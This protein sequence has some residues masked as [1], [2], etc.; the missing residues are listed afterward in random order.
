[1]ING[2]L[3]INKE[4]D[5]TSYDVIRQLKKILPKGQK[6]GHAGTLDPFAT[7]L[8][9]I[10]LGRSTKKMDDILKMNREYI[11]KA[12]FGYATDTQDVTGER[13]LQN[14]KLKEIQQEDIQREIEDEFSGIIKQIPPIYSAKK[15]KGKKAYEYAREKKEIE[16]EPREI[17]VKKFEI[18]DYNWPFVQF[19]ISC[20]SGTYVRTLVHDLGLKLETYATAILLERIKIG[21]FNVKDALNSKDITSD[22]DLNLFVIDYE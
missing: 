17:K 15:V 20:S 11:V 1:M 9:I 13:V 7:G 10:L 18:L 6:I 14:P 8:L 3:L 12:E 4:K 5:I 2:I 22:L 16:L 19:H 21:V